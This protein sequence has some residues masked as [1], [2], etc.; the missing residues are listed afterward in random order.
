MENQPPRCSSLEK[1]LL[2]VTRFVERLVCYKCTCRYFGHH[3]YLAVCTAWQFV[4]IN[5][6]CLTTIFYV[7]CYKYLFS[8]I[9]PR[10][11]WWRGSQCWFHDV[12][13]YPLIFWRCLKTEEELGETPSTVRLPTPPQLDLHRFSSLALK[14]LYNWK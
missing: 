12:D 13:N 5:K 6:T 4:V 9:T 1:K 14:L 8:K 2:F 11:E 3:P 7:V 10:S